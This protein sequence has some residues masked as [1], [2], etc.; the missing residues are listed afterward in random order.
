MKNLFIG[1]LLIV[2]SLASANNLPTKLEGVAFPLPAYEASPKQKEE[3]YQNLYKAIEKVAYGNVLLPETLSLYTVK[4]YNN[5]Y[6][7]PYA[8]AIVTPYQLN[9]EG[10]SKHPKF[11]RGVD[12]HEF[13]HSIFEANIL[14]ILKD[15]D[16]LV[17]VAKDYLEVKHLFKE[18]ALEM[19]GFMVANELAVKT[20]DEERMSTEYAN[21]EA[22]FNQ[23]GQEQGE[24]VENFMDLSQGLSPLNEFFADVFAVVITNDPE[25][26]RKA[27]EYTAHADAKQTDRSFSIRPGKRN[28]TFEFSPHNFYTLSR[29]YIYRNYLSNPEIR[30]KGPRWI[31]TR[32]VDSARCAVD[33]QTKREKELNEG[34]D[35]AKDEGQY[36]LETYN[37]FLNDCIDTAFKK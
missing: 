8:S 33:S 19:L 4:S 6:Y 15:N 3:I 20:P 5:A 17:K 7:F 34:Y 16:Q 28:V 13:A 35:K 9:I 25:V 27:I 18:E 14:T 37:R 32:V 11:T 21:A 23:A 12:L 26:I 29:Y 31:M 2:S 30:L 24:A 22:K 36:L 1:L 10:A